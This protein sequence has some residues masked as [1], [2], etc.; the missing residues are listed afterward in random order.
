LTQ[1]RDTGKIRTDN[2]IL[3]K[4]PETK[5]SAVLKTVEGIYC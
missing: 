5:N 1:S 3:T 2:R 4:T